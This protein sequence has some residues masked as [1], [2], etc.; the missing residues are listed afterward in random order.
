[1]SCAIGRTQTYSWLLPEHRRDAGGQ[2]PVKSLT[3]SPLRLTQRT[4]RQVGR[5][6]AS[7]FGFRS[8]FLVP[9]SAAAPASAE[10]FALLR[11]H[12]FPALGHAALPGPCRRPRTA[13][14]A[15]EDLAQDQQAQS[16]PESDG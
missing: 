9:V 16:L 5:R 2:N 10:F 14:A 1:M 12:L 11:R 4:R 3:A 13:E 7:R 15:E 6:T 8:F